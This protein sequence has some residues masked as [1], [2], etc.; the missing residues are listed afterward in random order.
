MTATAY[1]LFKSRETTA[2][3]EPRKS[4][5]DL[6]IMV[7]GT[8]SETTAR[9]TALTLCPASW[10]GKIFRSIHLERLAK[11]KWLAKAAYDDDEEQL[12]VG[13]WRF[14]FDTAGGNCKKTVALAERRY[15]ATAPDRQCAV[16]VQDGK[17]QGTDWPVG[18][19]KFTLTYRVPRATITLAWVRAVAA[20]VGR[21]NTSTFYGFAARELLFLGAKG[22]QGSKTDPQCDFDF[23]AGEHL[24][25]LNIGGIVVA[26]KE[27]H[28]YLWSSFRDMIET[29]GDEPALIQEPDAIY[30]NKMA[31]E[32]NFSALSIGTGT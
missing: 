24:I 14:S 19:L 1:E 17:V 13:E 4:S 6:L 8:D 29:G 21:T 7:R 26:L 3:I 23:L 11:Y 22:Q 31:Q 20:L 25:N 16:N 28:E 18:T 2:H 10:D 30:V 15:P 9:T 12:D 32:G 5:G 27:A